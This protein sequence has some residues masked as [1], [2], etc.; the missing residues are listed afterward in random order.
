MAS[1]LA[2]VPDGAPHLL[3]VDDEPGLVN[4]LT[5]L[6]EDHAME[7]H[8]A[9]NGKE[10]LEKIKTGA[11]D[12]VLSDIN[13]PEMS[14]LELLARV[15]QTSLETPFVFLTGFGDKEKTIEA[16]RLGATD[17]LDKPFDPEI[18]INVLRK[19]LELGHMMKVIEGEMEKLYTSSEIPVDR[20]LQLRKMKKSL[21]MM[22][23]AMNIYKKSA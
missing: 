13:M 23:H 11:Y 18:V 8:V 14:G 7:I 22:R 6:M 17:F 10:A 15:R 4:V 2:S 9:S 5:Q 12:A 16:L 20:R 19:A 1:A 3:I 21:V